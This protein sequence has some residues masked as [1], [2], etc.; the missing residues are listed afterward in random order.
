M[1]ASAGTTVTE[2]EM[3]KCAID[4]TAPTWWLRL[5]ILVTVLV[6]LLAL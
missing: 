6:A 2:R 4:S 1:K 3:I 5:I